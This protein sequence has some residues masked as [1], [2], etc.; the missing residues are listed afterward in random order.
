[1]PDTKYTTQKHREWVIKTLTGLQSDLKNIKETT[2]RNEKWLNKINGRTTKTEAK[3]NF[4][5]GV[6]SVVAVVF[7]GLITWLFKRV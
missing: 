6:S 7:G 5:Q 2:N 4:M 1:M 3:V